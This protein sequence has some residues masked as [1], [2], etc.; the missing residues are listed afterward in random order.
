MI[1][2]LAVCTAF[3]LIGFL[4]LGWALE[5]LDQVRWEI[6][7]LDAEEATRRHGCRSHVRLLHDQEVH[8]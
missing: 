6:E 1:V 7:R 3:L 5:E 8:R 4:I 2:L